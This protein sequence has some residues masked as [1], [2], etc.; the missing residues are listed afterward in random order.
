MTISEID[1]L[2]GEFTVEE[3]E[4]NTL[5][6][7]VEL[8]GEKAVVD[9]TIT[10]LRYRNKYPRV[11]RKVSLAISKE[12][13]KAVKVKKVLKDN[14]EKTV[15]VSDTDHIREFVKSGREARDKVRGLFEQIAPMEPLLVLGERGLG[16]RPSKTATDNANLFF[17]QGDD[18]VEEKVQVIEAMV[19]GYKVG[20]DV[21]N[22]VT[23]ESLARGIQMLNNYLKRQAQK[24]SQ[25]VLNT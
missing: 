11:Y 25:A 12:F 16:G 2:D 15:L 10:N 23:P 18:V 9:E 1:Y 6:E 4:P 8:F 21:E 7:V 19:P 22:A 3:E 13:P 20:R 5:K 14:S 24:Q 17:A